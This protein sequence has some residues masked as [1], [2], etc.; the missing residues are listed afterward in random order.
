MIAR[1]RPL[2][3]SGNIEVKRSVA[4]TAR[5]LPIDAVVQTACWVRQEPVFDSP[6]N[7]GAHCAKGASVASTA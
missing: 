4:R 2:R 6:L 3:K 5:G 1:P 7:L